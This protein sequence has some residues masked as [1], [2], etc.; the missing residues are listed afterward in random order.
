[1]AA[2][3]PWIVISSVLQ[4]WISIHVQ[5]LPYQAE[6]LTGRKKLCKSIFNIFNKQMFEPPQCFNHVLW[7]RIRC[8]TILPMFHCRGQQK[9]ASRCYFC[10]NTAVQPSTS[11]CPCHLE[12]L[13]TCNIQLQCSGEMSLLYWPCSS[14]GLQHI[15]WAACCCSSL[16][17]SA[18]LPLVATE[19]ARLRERLGNCKR[20]HIILERKHCQ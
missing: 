19:I 16:I 13:S 18:Q 5:T 2:S 4:L 6:E 8:L 7:L 15:C 20:D 12:S 9:L 1:M 17:L 14:V 11:V 10:C 3:Y